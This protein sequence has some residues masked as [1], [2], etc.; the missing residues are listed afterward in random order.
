MLLLPS[1]DGIDDLIKIQIG[2]T[3][4]R[5]RQF[6]VAVIFRVF[7]KDALERHGNI[8]SSWRILLACSKAIAKSR[9]LVWRSSGFLAKAFSTTRSTSNERAGLFVR[10]GGSVSLSFCIF[11]AC[12]PP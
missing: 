1:G 12:S 5:L 9:T 3:G 6:F 11:I 2:E 10:R 4:R 7:K 8:T